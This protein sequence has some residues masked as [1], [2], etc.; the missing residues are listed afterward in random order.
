MECLTDKFKRKIADQAF[1]SPHTFLLLDYDGTL[2][3]IVAKPELAKLHESTRKLLNKLVKQTEFSVGVITGRTTREMRALVHLKSLIYAGNHGL[4]LEGPDFK[5]THPK[6]KE[7]A[8]I[9]KD[10]KMALLPLL[11]AFPG[12]V[13]EDKHLT[14]SFHYRLVPFV[15]LCSLKEQFDRL[16]A[17]WVGNRKIQ[18]QEAKKVWEI[19]PHLNWNKGSAVRW[20]LL[21]EDPASFPIYIGDDK[22]DESAFKALKGRGITVRVGFDPASLA[23]YYVKDTNEVE[24]FLSFFIR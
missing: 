1:R 19:R 14:L 16:I 20:I 22:P 11:A 9:I 6:A 10:V 3:P 17:P 5:Y 23:R 13:M 2:T 21:H 24:R 7:S 12:T 15:K 8:R 18:I 4:E